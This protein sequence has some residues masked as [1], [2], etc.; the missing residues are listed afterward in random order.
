MPQ[1]SALNQFVRGA[2]TT[3]ERLLRAAASGTFLDEP[4]EPA[5]DAPGYRSGSTGK[6]VGYGVDEHDATRSVDTGRIRDI[7]KPEPVPRSTLTARYGAP[8]G[9]ESLRDDDD[10]TPA[11]AANN[12]AASGQGVILD[13]EATTGLDSGMLNDEIETAA[14]LDADLG[15]ADS[16]TDDLPAP[17]ERRDAGGRRGTV[18]QGF[19]DNLASG[20]DA[21]IAFTEAEAERSANE[22]EREE[23]NLPAWTISRGQTYLNEKVYGEGRQ[24]LEPLRERVRDV[25][26]TSDESL[27]LTRDEYD[28]FQRVVR[29]GA[30]EELD[31][32]EGREANIFGD[33]DQQREAAREARQGIINNPPS[34]G[35]DRR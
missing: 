13:E 33:A 30:D 35:G 23:F 29:E 4:P 5:P 14:G 1:Q 18:P 6:F 32:V 28:T 22:P 16:F 11:R 7:G 2:Q 3:Q 21:D 19:V 26:P 24:D 15:D 31:S 25:S 27:E 17:G 20:R 12:V 8:D 9:A 10:A 34:F